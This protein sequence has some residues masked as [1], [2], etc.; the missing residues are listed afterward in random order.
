[1]RILFA[2]V[3]DPRDVTAWSGTPF[4]MVRALAAAGVDVVLAAPLGERLG[5][6]WK[7]V[8]AARN[9]LG[10]GY[11]SR[12]REPSILAGHA[13]QVRRAI[14]RTEPDLVLAP[15]TLPV[16]RLRT[17]VPVVTWT[18]ATFAGMVGFY[19][20]YTGLSSRYTRLG[21]AMERSALERVSLAVY[22]SEWAARTAQESYGVP[23]DRTAV[24]P[25]GANLPD[26]GPPAPRA[27]D[28]TCRL[29][30]VGRGWHR[31][32]I[33]LAVETTER[34]RRKGVPAVLDV[35]GSTA[36]EG[37]VLPPFVTVHGALEKDDPVAAERIRGLYESADFFLLPT[38]ADCTPVVLA[39]AQAYGVPV[40]TSDV[41]GTASLLRPGHSGWTVGLDAFP[42]DAAA[43][44]AAAWETPEQHASLRRE[45]R[46]WYEG[47]LTWERSV[48]ALL[49]LVAER[50]LV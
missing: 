18:D 41:G 31:K 17:A 44:V 34:L 24:V 35:V 43:L 16:A 29:L 22:S 11:Y 26:P 8:Q 42:D 48:A 30:L 37:T 2:S 46:R 19:P 40:V 4:H 49:G 50:R 23:A 45:A 28:G 9:A 6:P 36:P 33:D 27:A 7:A 47:T 14:V 3:E 25:Y 5:L 20:S 21:H 39:E 10:G 13:A 1:M 12:L 32:G 15:S 38:R